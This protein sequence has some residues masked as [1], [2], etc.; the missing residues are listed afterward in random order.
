MGT[1]DPVGVA[2]LLSVNPRRCFSYSPNCVFSEKSEFSGPGSATSSAS[3][4]LGTN[5]I[6]LFIFLADGHVGGVE[7]GISVAVLLCGSL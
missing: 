3:L 5:G 4:L 1:G 6:R 2:F 7:C